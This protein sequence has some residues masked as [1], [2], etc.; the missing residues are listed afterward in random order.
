[1][2]GVAV[3]DASARGTCDVTRG[4]EHKERGLGEADPL[5]LTQVH[6]KQRAN[7]LCFPSELAC[8]L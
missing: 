7:V 1:M 3:K 8:K 6:F 2:A 4:L 5:S